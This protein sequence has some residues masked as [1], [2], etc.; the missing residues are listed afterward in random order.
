MGTVNCADLLECEVNESNNRRFEFKIT[1]KAAAATYSV[2]FQLSSSGSHI[3]LGTEYF[4][5]KQNLAFASDTS[6]W[7]CLKFA[8]PV[9]TGDEK[10]C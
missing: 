3:D 10:V 5:L 1:S 4:E 9:S 8:N 7:F 2:T 6:G